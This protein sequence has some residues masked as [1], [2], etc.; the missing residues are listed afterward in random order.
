MENKVFDLNEIKRI[1]DSLGQIPPIID[2]VNQ[3]EANFVQRLKD[4]N[5]Q[6][7][8]DWVNKDD[9]ATHKMSWVTEDNHAV[10]YP[11][12]QEIDGKL[13]DFSR[14]P[15]NKW[16][17]YRNAVQRGDTIHMTPQEAEWFTENYKDYYPGLN[18]YKNGGGI[19]INPANK[20]KFNATKKR[21]GKTTEELTHSK[22]PLTR[23]RAIFAQNARK[24]KH[25]E[26]GNLFQDGTDDLKTRLLKPLPD[27]FGYNEQESDNTYIDQ[28]DYEL[29]KQIQEENEQRMW[30]DI[31]Q[32]ML[33]SSE[34]LMDK[35][36][37]LVIN[38][39]S[40]K[41]LKQ[42][43]LTFAAETLPAMIISGALH[44][45]LGL[46]GNAGM[47][48]VGQK[49][50][51][52]FN[53]MIPGTQE[54]YSMPLWKQYA[55]GMLYTSDALN[56]TKE[57]LENPT[58]DNIGEA[59]LINLPF[60]QGIKNTFKVNAN[61]AYTELINKRN[62]N[63]LGE[64]LRKFNEA[65]NTNSKTEQIDKSH[66][67]KYNK[68]DVLDKIQKNLLLKEP[69][70]QFVRADGSINE[71]Q[72]R[73]FW[74]Q[75]S[76]DN[77]KYVDE[78]RLQHSIN[79]AKSAQELPL[80]KGYTRKEYVQTALLHDIGN[81]IQRDNHGKIGKQLLQKYFGN[82]L[83]EDQ[84]EAI[85]KHMNN[86]SFNKG[87][88]LLKAVEFADAAR[89]EN[90]AQSLAFHPNLMTYKYE[91]FFIKANKGKDNFIND[92]KTKVN[93]VLYN[94]NLG[95]ININQN[96]N[97][98]I[99]QLNEKT[100]QWRTL[101]RGVR[102]PFGTSLNNDIENRNVQNAEK[103]AIELFGPDKFNS[104]PSYY[105]AL[106]SAIGI[107][108]QP[109]G[110]GRNSLYEAFKMLDIGMP[111]KDKLTNSIFNK[112]YDALYASNGL[113]TLKQYQ[114]GTNTD[115]GRVALARKV[116]LP[117][118]EFDGSSLPSEWMLDNFD[119]DLLDQS[120][121]HQLS[122]D[123][124]YGLTRFSQ[125]DIPYRLQTGRSFLTDYGDW[126]GS[127]KLI[128][129]TKPVTYDKN[130]YLFNQQKDAIN[131]IN[132]ILNK[133]GF[134]NINPIIDETIY[135]TDK[136][137]NLYNL[138]NYIELLPDEKLN[139]VQNNAIRVRTHN[140]LVELFNKGIL[141]QKQI[142][143]HKYIKFDKKQLVKKALDEYYKQYPLILSNEF[144]DQ[145]KMMQFML[146]NG[147]EPRVLN[148]NYLKN[149]GVNTG[150]KD[151]PE[152]TPLRFNKNRSSNQVSIIGKR[153][154]QIFEDLGEFNFDEYEDLLKDNIITIGKRQDFGKNRIL[155]GTTKFKSG[156]YLDDIVWDQEGYRKYRMDD[157]PI[158]GI[159]GNNGTTTISTYGMKDKE[160]LFIQTEYESGVMNPNERR[161]FV[162]NYAIERP[163][164]KMQIGGNIFTEKHTTP[165]RLDQYMT[166]KQ[167]KNAQSIWNYLIDKGVSPR[168]AAVL[169][170]NAMQESSLNPNVRNGKSSAKG[171]FQVLGKRAEDVNKFIK[172]NK[173][174]KNLGQFDYF[175]DAIVNNKDMYM[176]GYNSAL[177]THQMNLDRLAEF[178]DNEG[179]QD[180]VRK[181]QQYIDDNYGYRLKNNMMFPV[182]D[183]RD[184]WNKNDYTLNE[185]TDLFEETFERAGK[186]AQH[187]KRKQYASD[188]YYW[189][190]PDDQKVEHLKYDPL[191]YNPE[192]GFVYDDFGNLK[193]YG[194]V[195]K[196]FSY[197]DIPEVRY[198]RGGYIFAPGSKIK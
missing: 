36:G 175:I 54:F 198:S 153:G 128:K 16:A 136:N 25:Q 154:S 99:Q 10:V 79:V 150:G 8:P 88:D 108:L 114:K 165:R 105:R 151:L 1:Y 17:G 34:L 66:S 59:A 83:S 196:P 133:Y 197:Y 156:G 81:I 194:G 118:E 160:S 93:P 127:G 158:M 63:E 163:V 40:E 38:P 19:H 103:Q 47:S 167:I 132:M 50:Y 86:E 95:K 82:S 179:L 189:F 46:F 15:Y 92:I 147:I 74:K 137:N 176:N 20:G 30:N 148:K 43:K 7:I 64:K 174:D 53:A 91:P 96:T 68:Q 123:K 69:K 107:P 111:L 35:N 124:Q 5:R 169:M 11:N 9:V 37:N 78:Y 188:F 22:N 97:D 3:S 42:D 162:G 180:I 131:Y 177:K 140:I 55:T 110:G 90:L 135:R 170:G 56:R 164:R 60:I 29:D 49:V 4:G 181:S 192:K 168:N 14:P 187:D 161:T 186:G 149:F 27:K 145:S 67:L 71:Q 138:I 119:W 80:P 182:S 139:D 142:E 120:K 28:R 33:E 94:A 39:L 52:G 21:T 76:T 101:F 143:K 141:T 89:G 193:Q 61:D 85:E 166:E 45:G 6:V 130:P 112:D 157:Q 87:K 152:G 185:L 195:T 155:T 113:Q 100:Q 106:V 159:L 191:N 117:F 57:A 48:N 12:V 32:H 144:L 24:W 146:E 18:E 31:N 13:Q 183:L 72:F 178:P 2:K 98:I 77:N 125:F 73:D 84:Y 126:F 41:G 44:G 129:N 62:A 65:Q 26:G 121:K 23:K 134:K 122:G 173:L 116:M 51:K 172:N 58:W 70:Y 184:K 190:T 171:Y 102:D 104:N 75:I 115:N 109:T